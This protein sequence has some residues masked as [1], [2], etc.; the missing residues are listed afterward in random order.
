M[1]N[2]YAGQEATVSTRH[3]T[4]DWFQIRRGVRQG[5]IWSLCLFNLYEEYIMQNTGLNEGQSGIKIA[6]RNINNFRYTNDAT[7]MA[8]SEE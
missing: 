5:S 4:T 7:L 6:G 2:V 8:E 1:R 3:G